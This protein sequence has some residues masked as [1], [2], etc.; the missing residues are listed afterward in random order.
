[1]VVKTDGLKVTERKGDRSNEISKISGNSDVSQGT[2]FKVN[3]N[4][5]TC[6]YFGHIP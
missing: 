2:H 6:I 4:D 3:T 1:M 5:I